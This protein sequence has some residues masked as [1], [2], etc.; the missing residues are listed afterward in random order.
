MKAVFI[1]FQKIR[2]RK[3]GLVI[4]LCIG[5][6]A[7][8]AFWA[9]GRMNEEMLKQGWMYFL[10]QFPV[11]NTIMMPIVVSVVASR[12]CDIEHKGEMYKLLYTLLPG[13]KLFWAKFVCGS[14]F[15]AGA[16]IL[17]TGVIICLGSL[18]KFKGELPV[19]QMF[20]FFLVSTAINLTILLFQQVLSLYF[21]NQMIPL[22][23]GLGGCFLGL[24]SLFFPGNLKYFLIWGYYGAMSGV[25][26][27]WN[28]ETRITHFYETGMN[29]NGMLLLVIF[30][31]GIYCLGYNLIKRKEI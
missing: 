8:W 18:K 20:M 19:Q 9:A 7:L 2:H 12:I 1:E 22:S 3:N 28:R 25:G 26:M 29:F 27:D 15:M 10:Y 23:V 5:A 17:Q 21:T 14:V 31:A 13:Y 6:Q 11:L 4:I 30:F 16:S 24:F